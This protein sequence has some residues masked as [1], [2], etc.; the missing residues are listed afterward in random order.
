MADAAQ[1][2]GTALPERD[3]FLRRQARAGGRCRTRRSDELPVQDAAV[4]LPGAKLE[5]K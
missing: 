3:S 4:K 2:G 1:A 5:M